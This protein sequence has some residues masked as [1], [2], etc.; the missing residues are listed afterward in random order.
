MMVKNI[1][2]TLTESIREY[3]N[4]ELKTGNSPMYSDL[5]MYH[6][7][8]SIKRRI[9]QARAELNQLAKDL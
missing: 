2:D 8:G 3:E 1:V 9:T 5:N 4:Y 7:K 6:T